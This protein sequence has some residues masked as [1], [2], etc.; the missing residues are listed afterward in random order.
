MALLTSSG[1]QLFQST[2]PVRGGTIAH[3]Q[4]MPD[5]NISIHP[6][7]AGRDAANH[8]SISELIAISIHPPRAGRDLPG[9]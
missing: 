8:Q 2:R 6:P 7:R 5:R 4:R 3:A 1:K 9:T